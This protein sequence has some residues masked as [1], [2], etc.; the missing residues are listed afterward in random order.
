LCQEY[1]KTENDPKAVKKDELEKVIKKV[2][3]NMPEPLAKK[4]YSVI[5][6][7]DELDKARYDAVD[8]G[9]VK[10]KRIRDKEKN[11]DKH[12]E[13]YMTPLID[14]IDTLESQLE[15]KVSKQTI[16]Y[17]HKLKGTV[18]YGV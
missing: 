4:E 12:S 17:Y 16:K 7:R 8:M 5:E 14:A 18:C 15:K 1:V 11:I 2:K 3:E 10:G 13:G 9:D 6:L